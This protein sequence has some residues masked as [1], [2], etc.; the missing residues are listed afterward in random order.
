MNG[1]QCPSH[2]S[3]HNFE[4]TY[5]L[6]RRCPRTP[7]SRLAVHPDRGKTAYAI[8]HA[9][10]LS[11][12]HLASLISL[13]AVEDHAM[14]DNVTQTTVNPGQSEARATRGRECWN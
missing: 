1:D 11:C 3:K 6:L 5:A 13:V 7:G 8:G 2:L 14:L 10:L 4:H 9:E 12:G